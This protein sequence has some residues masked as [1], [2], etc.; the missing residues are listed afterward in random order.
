MRI[1]T[2]AVYDSETGTLVAWEGYEWVGP[3]AHCKSK[4]QKEQQ[5]INLDLA[6]Q[7]SAQ[8]RQ[9]AETQRAL[10][11][12]QQ[13]IYGQISPFALESMQIGRD[14]LTGKVPEGLRNA[15]LL[16]A[17]TELSKA[18]QGAR[19]NL[20]EALGAA[21]QWGS[22][23]SAG[24]LANLET[25]QARAVGDVTMNANLQALIQAL[26]MG[27]QGAGLLTG[28]Q[29]IFNPIPYGQ[30]GTGAAQTALVDPRQYARAGGGTA[31]AIVGGALGAAGQI[32]APVPTRA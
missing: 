17:R 9:A 11:A 4:E 20:M 14:A 27:Q 23:I 16:P 28:Q 13:Q 12:Q 10:L 26:Q 31:G 1:T 5:K 24:P 25:E 22:G 8:S 6:Q 3:V 19:G 32:L 21:G 2:K 15:Y 30:L 7:Q 29:Q 18:F